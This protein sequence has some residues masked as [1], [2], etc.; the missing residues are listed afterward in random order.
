MLQQTL[1]VEV[2]GF[3]K[4]DVDGTAYCKLY[5]A[6]QQNDENHKGIIPLAL[7]ADPVIND[8]LANVSLPR[9]LDVRVRLQMAAGGRTG[10]HALSVET[11]MSGTPTPTAQ[12]PKKD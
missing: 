11:G 4:V 7:N 10:M 6:Q 2:L 5:I 1:K 8:Q 12:Q 9:L 3:R